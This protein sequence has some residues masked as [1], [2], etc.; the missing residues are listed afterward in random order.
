MICSKCFLIH[1]KLILPVL[2]NTCQV[3]VLFVI[4]RL[5]IYPGIHVQVFT[6]YKYYF[7]LGVHYV[8][9]SLSSSL[10]VD[11]YVVKT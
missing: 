5:V 4:T 2:M 10:V 7:I 6:R 8:Q 11:V 9:S 1:K 3:K